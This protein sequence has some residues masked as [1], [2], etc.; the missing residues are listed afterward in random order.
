MVSIDMV[1]RFRSE[2]GVEKIHTIFLTDGDTDGNSYYYDG[3]RDCNVSFNG[4]RTDVYLRDPTTKV[5]R[6]IDAWNMTDDLLMFLRERTGAEAVGFFILANTKQMPRW[7]SWDNV[8]EGRKE[9]KKN[10]FTTADGTGYSEF[11]LIKGGKDLDTSTEE[12]T[13]KEDAKR[14]AMTTAFKKFA[15]GKRVS[16]VLL[17]RFVDM[18]A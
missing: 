7:K 10:G 3:A 18:V 2:T 17:S 14:G 1:N 8:A 6:K 12:L 15:K 5:T 13:I 4:Y 9:L 11:Y 16:K